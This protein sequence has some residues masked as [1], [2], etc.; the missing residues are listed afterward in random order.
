MAGDERV[1]AAAGNAKKLSPAVSD[2]LA[3]FQPC[4]AEWFRHA[5]GEP[6]KAQVLGW[7]PIARGESTLLLAPTGSGKT[8]AAFLV[9][10]DRLI[11]EAPRAKRE[12]TRVLYVSPLKALAIDVERNLRAP[13]DG[14]KTCG[15]RAGLALHIPTV[16][17]R[18]GDTPSNVRARMARSPADILVTTPESLYLMLTSAARETLVSIDTLIID[19]IHALVAT[20][21]G[22]HLALSIERLEALRPRGS[23]PLQRI[24]LSATQRPLDEV[25]RLLGGLEVAAS[26]RRRTE[27]AASEWRRTERTAPR[28][29]TIADAGAR[30][31]MELVV[32]A[33]E[34][35]PRRGR[36]E[37]AGQPRSVWPDVHARVVELVL[38]HRSTIVFVNSRRLAER[39]AAAVNEVAGQDIALAHHGSLA[40][41][42]R[43]AI[44]EQL[45]QGQV[46]AI[47]ATSSLELGIDMGAV[48]LVIQIESPPSVTSGLQ[49]VGRAC[50]GVGGVPRGVLLPK[51]RQDLVACAA[52]AASM[53]A[54]E[55]EETFYP[56]NPLDVLAQQIVAM[57]SIDAWSVEELFCLVRRAA[58]FADLPRSAF[59]GLLDM[60]SG[61]YPSDD[62]A[63]L[64]PR[65]TWDRA[66]GRIEG[67]AG[68]HRLAVTSGGTIPDR[69]LYGVFTASDG[70]RVGELDEEMVFEL[71][72]GEV[73]LL[74]ASSWRAEQITHDRVVV[75]PA[76]GQPGKMPFWHGDRAGRARAL[77]VRIG[78]LVRR[79]AE[80]G[81]DGSMLCETHA[82]SRPAADGLVAYVRDQVQATGEVPSDQAIV[83]ERFV[84]EVGDWRVVV[85][86][87]LGTRV[88]APWAIAVAARLREAYVDV[89]LHYTDDGMAFRI[90]ACETPPPPELFLPQA[91]AIEAMVTRALDGTALF[92]ARF[93]ECAARALLLPR[94]DPRRR[95]PLWAQ[96]KRA[97]DLLAVAS[98]HP[99]FPIVLEAY[100]ECL[101]DAFDLPGLVTLLRDIESRRVRAAVVDTRRPS[102]FSASVLFAFVANFI[103][104]ADAPPAERRAQALTID[105]ERLKELLGDSELRSLLDPDTIEEHQA[106]LQRLSRPAT[107]L[108]AL[109]D[110]LLS[111][112]DLSL[113]EVRARCLPG[114]ADEWARALVQAR[115]AVRAR[116]AGQDRLAAVE[117]AAKVRDAL[118]AVLPPGLPRALL[119]PS[120]DPLRELVARFARTHG[121]FV[122]GD[123]AR[124]LG[125]EPTAV[126]RETT[127]LLGEGRLVEGAFL[128][129]GTQREL[130]SR[131][132]LDALR[133]KSLA[134][135]RRAIEPVPPEALARLLPEWQGVTQKRRGR[136]ALRA[137]IG[138]LQ[139]CPLV[140][141]TLESEILPARLD[142]YQ[143]WDL[144]AL[145]A[146]GEVVW[147][148]LEPVGANDGRI[149]LYLAEHEARLARSGPPAPG[150]LAAAIRAVLARRGAVFF[151][152]VVREVGGFP[153]DVFEALW[154]MVWA[155]EIT[156]DTF[157]PLRALM[158]SSALRRGSE[159]TSMRRPGAASRNRY[160]PVP[161][162]KS[163]GRWS[164]RSSRWVQAPSDTDRSMALARALLDRYGVVTREAAHAEGVSGGFAAVYEV[165][166][167]LENQGRV[168]R[169]Y[170]VEGRGGAQ[171][172]LPG[173][174][175]RLR[176]LRSK[177]ED[178]RPLVLAA[179]DPANAWGALLEWPMSPPA[180]GGATMT[181]PASGGATM[182]P[183]ASG[184]ATMTPPASGGATMTPPP[185]GGAPKTRAE[186]RP[187]RSAGAR[188]VLQDGSLLGWMGRG[189]HPLI[190]FL[191]EGE[192]GRAEAARVL[193]GALAGLVDGG[194][195]PTLIVCSIDGV[196]A[197]DSPLRPAFAQAGF[198]AT[199]RGLLKRRAAPAPALWRGSATAAGRHEGT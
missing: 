150:D 57:A 141:S 32:E 139:G 134:R 72:E 25:A 189:D 135:L 127:R 81:V 15:A 178:A 75:S 182:T 109:H 111:V 186:A 29:V 97:G 112:G 128:R 50:H 138:E 89:D 41:E 107:S 104:E 156:N 185:S 23:R 145:C 155:G 105:L 62:F 140:A 168:R 90:P 86:C 65:I 126:E 190:T 170:F 19:E 151:A 7:P 184:G 68:A 77:G 147:A 46:R 174:D 95:T 4:V 61:R 171:F 102:P 53:R 144:D 92:A 55:V 115:R 118:G 83:I 175:E 129:A 106:W 110:V 84:D 162:R 93:R 11:R 198:V 51:H 49:R 71:R 164:L 38:A 70:A 122:V 125:V 28:A 48:D 21:R 1:E 188:V 149:A 103:Y 63:E 101:R 30:K 99:S 181:P 13:I 113:D 137:V 179:T 52:A 8:L 37:E 195:R 167:A 100:R 44:E 88:L 153:N 192:P 193:A 187:Q 59:D 180:S 148:G 130:C 74:G 177:R 117:D 173:A 163:E 47:V 36:S 87:P 142:A 60:L 33:A 108:D 24:G 58:P 56:R 76:A 96:R 166:K 6:T 45:K 199:A 183:P 5:L 54:A 197:T 98:R 43:S 146:T 124:R 119:E 114:R 176:G 143:P 165:L 172:S 35:S 64:R 17:V 27:N 39:L 157:E 73:F 42:K 16:D 123:V 34:S 2:S 31:T 26:E 22:A 78:E 194:S 91:D 169:G 159:A 40:R 12:R 131:D 67:R 196:A 80:G 136:D 9:A 79:I 69:G 120:V 160:R 152:D 161:Q 94:R 133:R 18:T 82:L 132:V 121:P 3:L 14:I 158:P 191:P 85:L 116:I 20:K 154:Q 66:S 10:I